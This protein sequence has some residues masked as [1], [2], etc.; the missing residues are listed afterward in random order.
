MDPVLALV[1]RQTLTR[2]QA[3]A[4]VET[5]VLVVLVARVSA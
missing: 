5:Q 4:V 3:V 2:A 1:R